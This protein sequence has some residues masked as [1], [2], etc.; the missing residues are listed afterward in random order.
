MSAQPGI[1]L[2]DDDLGVR[3]GLTYLLSS[4]APV[5]PVDSWNGA[6]NLLQREPVGLVVTD[7]QV[8]SEE[9]VDDLVAAI[10]ALGVPMILCTGAHPEELARAR[11]MFRPDVLL[12][13]P[14]SLDEMM[15]AVQRL[16][17]KVS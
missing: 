12:G 9:G 10:R 11:S 1:L 15:D 13:K 4:F 8:C 3:E 16:Y 7:Y 14:F 17:R 6:L 2:I 5:W